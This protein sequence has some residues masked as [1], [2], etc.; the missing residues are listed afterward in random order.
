[1][2]T[3]IPNRIAPKIPPKLWQ[4]PNKME[5]NK[6][7]KEILFSALLNLPKNIPL[8]KISSIIGDNMTMVRK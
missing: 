5:L 3:Q 6:I 7:A 2:D 1:M 8:N 4:M